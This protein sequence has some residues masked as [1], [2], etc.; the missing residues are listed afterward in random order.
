[1]G[2]CRKL[3]RKLGKQDEVAGISKVMG[4]KCS[5]EKT[6]GKISG[7]LKRKMGLP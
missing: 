5:T 2:I 1:M 3:N 4:G 7:K 6:C